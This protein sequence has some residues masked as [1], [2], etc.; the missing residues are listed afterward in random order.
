M[1]HAAHGDRWLA[2]GKLKVRFKARRRARAT[3]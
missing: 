2:T 1:M 3:R